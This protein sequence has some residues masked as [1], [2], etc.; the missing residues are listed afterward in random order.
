M[1]SPFSNENG[2][3]TLV[4]GLYC[5]SNY[6]YDLMKVYIQEELEIPLKKVMKIDISKGKFYVY[7][8]DGS[9][10]EGSIKDT[11]KYDWKSCKYCKDFSAELADISIGS[12]GAYGNDWNSVI[13]RTDLGKKLFNSAVEA[14][15]IITSKEMDRAKLEE[16]SLRKKTR[17]TQIDQKILDALLLLDITDFEIKTYTTLMSLGFANTSILSKIMNAEESSVNR[18]LSKLKKREWIIN[19]NGL[20]SSANPT[21]VINSEI[22]K[23]RRDFLKKIEN[24]KDEVLPNLETLYAQNNHLRHEDL[25]LI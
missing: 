15:K 2:K 3:F 6:S 4:L 19:N 25:D 10:K 20:Y 17:L 22:S 23:L 1:S 13:V 18:T 11:K 5:Y 14:K 24:L 8:N 21:L 12:V 9:I 16:K 7:V